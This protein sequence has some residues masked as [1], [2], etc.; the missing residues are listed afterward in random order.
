MSENVSRSLLGAASLAVLLVLP[1]GFFALIGLGVIAPEPGSLP[2]PLWAIGLG[3]L[4][5]LCAGLGLLI[6]AL[7]QAGRAG[8][9]RPPSLLFGM[10]RYFAGL[11]TTTILA[12]SAS[13]VAFYTGPVRPVF[14]AGAALC[15]AVLAAQAIVGWRDLRNSRRPNI[16]HIKV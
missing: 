3:G 6:A 15:W 7:A 2:V 14:A 9:S 8:R 16:H 12:G 4:V 10:V 11:L 13:W 1:G 5:L